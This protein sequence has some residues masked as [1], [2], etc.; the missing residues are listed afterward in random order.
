MEWKAVFRF[1]SD[2]YLKRHF[3]P[4]PGETKWGQKVQ[5]PQGTD[6]WAS[7][8]DSPARFVLLGIPEDIGV[9]ANLGKPGAASLWT[10]TLEALLQLQAQS[11][12]SPDQ[13]FLLGEMAVEG[14]MEAAVGQDP[15]GLRKLVEEMD[16]PVS[17]LIEAIVRLDKIPLVVGGG[18]NQAYGLLKGA[19][20]ARDRPVNAINLD[21][22]ADFRAMEG[23]HS[24]NGFRY[25]RAR[26]YLDHYAVLGLA[27]GYNAPSMIK[28][29][30]GD[31]R[32]FIR[33]YE[34]MFLLGS[35]RFNQ[36]LESALN[37]LGRGEAG[38]EL[39][40]DA[41]D[42]VPSSAMSWG[43]FSVREARIYV[44]RAA[45]GLKP[46]YF[47]LTEGAV[48]LEGRPQEPLVAKLAAQLLAD[49]VESV[50]PLR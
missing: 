30:T 14:W 3:R 1:A 34:D 16:T 49:F 29:L 13:V 8:V 37:F 6:P 33:F 36:E 39:D 44:R 50:E 10:P 35:D 42:G 7:L 18:H 23:R 48:S 5:I 11:D 22:H 24:G 38:V 4:R 25:A 19:S 15:E 47:H 20:G 26:N 21:A 9:R 31:H 41:L 32:A 40:M 27:R 28:E 43:G 45:Q 17:E 12:F 46:L 2:E